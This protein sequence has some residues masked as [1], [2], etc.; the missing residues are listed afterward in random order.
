MQL[1]VLLSV[2]NAFDHMFQTLNPSDP[3]GNIRRCL[4]VLK[5]NNASLLRPYDILYS[6][7]CKETVLDD[8][9][10]LVA[11]MAAV[12]LTFTFHGVFIARHLGW[13]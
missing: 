3:N 13:R 7:I 2:R 8:V 9:F 6:C 4:D 10:E 12:V 1:E 11:A 5:G